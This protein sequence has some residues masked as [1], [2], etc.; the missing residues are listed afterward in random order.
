M[1]TA[2]LDKTKIAEKTIEKIILSSLSLL[3]V[4][5]YDFLNEFTPK[6]LP[7]LSKTP[8]PYCSKIVSVETVEQSFVKISE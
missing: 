8:F 5:I 3:D 7:Q 6:L 2:A 1:A 4:D